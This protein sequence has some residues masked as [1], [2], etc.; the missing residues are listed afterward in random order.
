VDHTLVTDK[1][2]TRLT[3]GIDEAG[4][5]PGIGP[6]VLAAACLD[7]NGARTLSRAGLADSKS[8]GAGD[9]ARKRRDE[10][11]A[12]VREVAIWTMTVVDEVVLHPT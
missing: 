12:R 3:L 11:A 8:Y 7:T 4:R 9:K 1:A 5:G 6:M 10:L 2:T